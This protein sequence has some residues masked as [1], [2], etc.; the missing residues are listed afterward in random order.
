METWSD[1]T[2]EV[3]G[4]EDQD[5]DHHDDDRSDGRPAGSARGISHAQPTYGR[6]H[7]CETPAR[8]NFVVPIE[9]RRII[10]RGDS[11]AGARS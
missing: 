10:L 3:K 11:D 1:G 8:G 6:G 4:D 5:E 7:P 9:W 2:G